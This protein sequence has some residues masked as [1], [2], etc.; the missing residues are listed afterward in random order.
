MS[1]AKDV[2]L[3]VAVQLFE[4]EG[5][6]IGRGPGA[7][8][9]EG[10]VTQVDEEHGL[11]AWKPRGLFLPCCGTGERACGRLLIAEWWSRSAPS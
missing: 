2:D 6:L 11:P 1:L 4:A 5:E 8:A 9:A 10:A 3:G 7:A